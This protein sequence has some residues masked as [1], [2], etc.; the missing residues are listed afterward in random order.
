MSAVV[1][2]ACPKH[3]ELVAFDAPGPVDPPR[4][5]WVID[6]SPIGFV[7]PPPVCREKLERIEEDRRA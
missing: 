1:A 5:C 4:E 2:F 7:C 3:G 6:R